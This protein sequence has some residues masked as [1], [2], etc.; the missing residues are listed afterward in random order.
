MS[1]DAAG[2]PGIGRVE[3]AARPDGGG[4]RGEIGVGGSGVIDVVRR[5][6]LHTD[7]MGDLHEGVVA[8]VIERIAVVPY[9]DEHTIASES[10]DESLQ[11]NARRR[12]AVSHQRARHQTAA[13]TGQHPTRSGDGLGDPLQLEDRRALR[14][15]ELTEG[16]GAGESRVTGGAIGEEDETPAGAQP[17]RGPGHLGW[18]DLGAEHGGDPHL[19]RC[20]GEADHP[21][22]AVAI[23]DGEGLKPQPG[24]FDHQRLRM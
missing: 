5:D 20:L 16:E 21:V 13:A 22:E 4:D 3:T 14:T 11:F 6:A 23:G 9:L 17:S 18:R 12:R 24:R 1:A 19:A 10:V 7:A 2:K 15:S 8:V